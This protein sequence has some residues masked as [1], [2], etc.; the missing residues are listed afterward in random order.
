[1]VGHKNGSAGEDRC[2]SLGGGLLMGWS[3][4]SQCGCDDS[5]M[6]AWGSLNQNGDWTDCYV[7]VD[8]SA[9]PEEIVVAALA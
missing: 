1:M 5:L 8:G 3:M 2:C 7:P 6:E 4:A 9:V